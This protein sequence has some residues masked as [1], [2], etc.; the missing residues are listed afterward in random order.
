MKY[1]LGRSIIGSYLQRWPQPNSLIFMVGGQ[2]N[3]LVNEE[4]KK[5]LKTPDDLKIEIN[6]TFIQ[7]YNIKFRAN[8]NSSIHGL[9]IFQ[10]DIF[11]L[12]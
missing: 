2:T 8:F 5:K 7:L 3:A 12:A 6:Y 11:E 4:Q 1:L 10:S 9:T